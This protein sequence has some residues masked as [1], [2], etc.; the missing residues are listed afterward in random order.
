MMSSVLM[1]EIFLLDFFTYYVTTMA[2]FCMLTDAPA[3]FLCIE[4]IESQRVTSYPHPTTSCTQVRSS[5][6]PLWAVRLNG[7]EG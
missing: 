4:Q 3:Y 2:L 7:Y 1:I 6:E 5:L